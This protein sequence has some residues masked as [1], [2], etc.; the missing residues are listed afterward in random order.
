M[1]YQMPHN[2]SPATTRRT[3]TLISGS[4]RLDAGPGDSGKA[5]DKANVGRWSHMGEPDCIVL[6]FHPRH[7]AETGPVLANLPS[8]TNMPAADL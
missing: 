2:T 4:H 7:K 8:I 1:V 3:A 6:R 5:V